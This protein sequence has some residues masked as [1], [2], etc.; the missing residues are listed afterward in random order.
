[1]KNILVDLLPETVEVDGSE[2]A[3]NTDFRIGILFEELMQDDTLLSEEKLYSAL[4]LY[5][6]QIPHNIA[7]AVEKLQW[8]YTGGKAIQKNEETKVKKV[9]SSRNRNIYSYSYDDEYIYSAFLTQ[10]RVD[11]QDI[12]HLHWWKFKAMFNA[13]NEE[14]KII[15]IMGYRSMKITNDMSDSQK[16]YYREMK[17]L[18]ALPDLRTEEEKEMEFHEAL[19]NAI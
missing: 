6:N 5:Y 3:I 1:M 19:S 9:G 7:E 12:K 14:N 8:F 15:K 4:R 17:K 10:Y 11:L 18:Y 13:L 2:Y 16:K